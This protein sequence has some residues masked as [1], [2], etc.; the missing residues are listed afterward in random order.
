MKYKDSYGY[1]NSIYPPYDGMVFKPWIYLVPHK[2]PKSVLMLGYAGGT[3]AGLIR[4]IYGNVPITGVDIEIIDNV[5]HANLVRMD[6][7]DYVKTC[8][9]YEFVLVDLFK[10]G[11]YNEVD[12]LT[13]TE[14]AG[15]LKRISDY[16]T[17]HITS[18]RDMSVFKGMDL[19]TITLGSHTFYYY[20]QY[21][22]K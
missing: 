21:Y 2:R 1:I 16:L 8:G 6:A 17:I 22:L 20:S 15:N 7:R 14:F 9:K 11:E 4:L 12:F 18:Q 3:V 13:D 10:D 5:Y 19:R